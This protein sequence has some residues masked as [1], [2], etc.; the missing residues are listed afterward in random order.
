MSSSILHRLY[1]TLLTIYWTLVLHV[2]IKFFNGNKF[3]SI[4]SSAHKKYKKAYKEWYKNN[5][6]WDLAAYKTHPAWVH[7][8]TECSCYNYAVANQEVNRVKCEIMLDEDDGMVHVYNVRKRNNKVYCYDILG[9]KTRMFI[10]KY[11]S[12]AKWKVFEYDD[13]IY[14][15]NTTSYKYRLNEELYI[16]KQWMKAI[17]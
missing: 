17:K 6:W 8:Y 2:W 1:V 7:R 16:L 14:T 12:L 13:S 3:D 5:S 4:D 11:Y 10:K 15:D 9:R